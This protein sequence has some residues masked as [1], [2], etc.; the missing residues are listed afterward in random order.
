MD[1]VPILPI[2]GPAGGV[3]T[4]FLL[5]M[6][7]ARR[8]VVPAINDGHRVHTQAIETQRRLTEALAAELSAYRERSQARETA[9][10]AR[11]ARAE[12]RLSA[13]GK[14]LDECRAGERELLTRV[15]VL[16]AQQPRIAVVETRPATPTAGD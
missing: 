13:M 9:A 10:A 8:L 1:L 3:A 16:E 15:A 14:R 5:G 2:L 11:E 6:L 12:E 7:M 4:G